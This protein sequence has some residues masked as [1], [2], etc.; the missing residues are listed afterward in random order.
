MNKTA[1]NPWPFSV[2]L[3]F[4]QAQLVEGRRRELI[5][6]AQDSVDENAT[7]ARPPADGPT[8][9]RDALTRQRSRPLATWVTWTSLEP[10]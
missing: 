4:D 5:C 9:D 10:A 7:P 8:T 1:I 2:Q 6:S 3:G